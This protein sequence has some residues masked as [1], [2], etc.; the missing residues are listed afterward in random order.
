MPIKIKVNTSLGDTTVIVF[1]NS[2]NQNFQFNVNG[3]PTSINF[4]YGNWILKYVNGITDTEI[5][6]IPD[7]YVLKQNYPNPFNPTTTIEYSV[8][9]S[10]YVTLKVFNVLGKEVATLVNGQN[11]AGRHKVNF[12][13]STLNSGVYFYRIDAD[14]FIDT[15]KMILLK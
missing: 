4:D 11:G 7:E 8:P 12:D 9:Q 10:S 14:N 6:P 5:L 2:Q 15:K 13:A 1:N 3:N